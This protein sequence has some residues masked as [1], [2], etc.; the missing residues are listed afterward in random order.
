MVDTRKYLGPARD[1][2]QAEAARLLELVALR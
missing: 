2:V 1:A